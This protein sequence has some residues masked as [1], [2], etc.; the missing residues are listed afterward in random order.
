MINFLSGAV[1]MGFAVG[2]LFFLR[3]WRKSRERLFLVFAIAFSLLALNQ[4]LIAGLDVVN[5][6]YSWI[7][8]IRVLAFI[9]IIG[10]IIDKNL[11]TKK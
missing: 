2:A 1:T 3:F 5:E 6:A 8:A 10:A 4:A 9:L 11:G 7:Y